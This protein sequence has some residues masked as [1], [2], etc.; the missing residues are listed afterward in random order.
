MLMYAMNRMNSTFYGEA[1]CTL[2]L[3][4]G[5]VPAS[6]KDLRGKLYADM[7]KDC[8][9]AVHVESRPAKDGSKYVEYTHEYLRK[10][11]GRRI[12]IA[13]GKVTAK[14]VH[15]SPISASYGIDELEDEV[16]YLNG[17]GPYDFL[18]RDVPPST[19]VHG[20]DYGEL[21]V[22]NAAQYTAIFELDS[23]AHI[24]QIDFYQYSH[25]SNSNNRFYMSKE[26]DCTFEQTDNTLDLSG[27]VESDT[28]RM[29]D[30]ENLPDALKH[31]TGLKLDH[32]AQY[33]ED[34]DN[35]G[36]YIWVKRSLYASFSWVP[37]TTA[38]VSWAANRNYVTYP[39]NSDY[40]DEPELKSRYIRHYTSSTSSFM[41]HRYIHFHISDN[42]DLPDYD[43][44]YPAT[45]ITWAVLVPNFANLQFN[46][47]WQADISGDMPAML[48][49]VGGPNDKKAVSLVK[50][51]Q[52]VAS[53]D[54]VV[55]NLK[56][57]VGWMEAV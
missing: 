6:I 7:M 12:D 57:F 14:A 47:Y 3:M 29:R 16:T 34:P 17:V 10:H 1:P 49:D 55:L 19:A 33:V 41:R 53:D 37:Y 42:A 11:V 20:Y 22:Y 2:F 9:A 8:V 27:A 13:K 48:L 43:A 31:L 24:K 52:V 54:I 18:T 40:I 36:E 30:P 21:G 45:D 50:D 5:A 44:M 28:V 23:P 38:N 25:T 32:V 56:T 46:T 35:Q 26:Y 51:K 39:N 4:D 15:R